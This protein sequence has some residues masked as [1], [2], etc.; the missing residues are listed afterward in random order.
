MKFAPGYFVLMC[1]LGA[2]VADGQVIYNSAS[3]AAEA[4]Q[5]GMSGIISAQGQ[6]NLSNSQAAI[7]MTEARSS[8][9]DNQ[10]KSVNAYWEEKGIYSQHQQQQLAEI[11]Q[12]RAE[13]LARHGLKSLTPQEFDRTT[14]QINWPRIMEQKAYAPYRDKIDELFHKR[15]YYGALTGDEYVEATVALREWRAALM[16]QQDEYPDSILSQ[17]LRFQLKVKRELDDNLG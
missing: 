2:C 7:N 11:D 13:Y 6:R 14:G 12:K 16:K 1:A 17:M 15:S 5:R 8:Q 10:V 3:T 4:S 9:I